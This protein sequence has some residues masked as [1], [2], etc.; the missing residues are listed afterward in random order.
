M[1]LIF[2]PH[3]KGDRGGV[4]TEILLNDYIVPASSSA[5]KSFLAK[6]SFRWLNL[7]LNKF[8]Q[9]TDPFANIRFSIELQIN[10]TKNL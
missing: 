1:K 7:L 10:E 3:S 5:I 4:T 6:S 2:Y 8:D 9:Q